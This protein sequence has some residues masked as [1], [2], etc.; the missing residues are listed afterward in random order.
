M[1]SRKLMVALLVTSDDGWSYVRL[2]LSDIETNVMFS[3]DT[4]DGLREQLRDFDTIGSRTETPC[5]NFRKFI[6][7]ESKNTMDRKFIH[8]FIG[9]G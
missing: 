4:E 5:S 3:P 8:T 2:F 9:D 7:L 1:M 6:Q